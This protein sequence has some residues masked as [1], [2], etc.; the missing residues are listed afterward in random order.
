MNQIE[1]SEVL[2]LM[3]LSQELAL[4]ANKKMVPT[5]GSQILHKSVVTRRF[6][7]GQIVDTI[8]SQAF[9]GQPVQTANAYGLLNYI[10]M[11]KNEGTFQ[12]VNPF[13]YITPSKRNETGFRNSTS[14][15]I[16]GNTV[17]QK[18]L[19]CF[20]NI[21]STAKQGSIGDTDG[22]YTG[23]QIQYKDGWFSCNTEKTVTVEYI[24]S[25]T[26]KKGTGPLYGT[27]Q[28]WN[29]I[30]KRMPPIIEKSTKIFTKS[31]IEAMGYTD[32][33]LATMS[34]EKWNLV[35]V[36]PD[37]ELAHIALELQPI[38]EVQDML[39]PQV[40]INGTDDN[41]FNFQ[42]LNT[43]W[44]GKMTDFTLKICGYGDIDF[45]DLFTYDSTGRATLKPDAPVFATSENPKLFG[46]RGKFSE[47]VFENEFP[48]IIKVVEG[49]RYLATYSEGILT[50][51]FPVGV[52]RK[53][54][55]FHIA[56]KPDTGKSDFYHIFYNL[57]SGEQ[58]RSFWNI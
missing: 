15:T 47:T 51:Q 46:W 53:V 54:I 25:R 40:W 1:V 2:D 31:E 16:E 39:F 17:I 44:G 12:E 5:T 38:E 3:E 13:T 41:D 11:Q 6:V 20:M 45:E 32:E 19:G 23:E 35:D 37:T 22:V 29:I 55:G 21:E 7:S 58:T 24:A 28:E 27:P 26:R 14:L 8:E 48:P 10:C 43:P 36:N 30:T 49:D 50:V 18:V 4:L 9:V 52:N 56:N 33:Q 57:H 42:A 34:F